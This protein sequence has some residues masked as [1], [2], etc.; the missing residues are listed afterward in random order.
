[1]M[2]AD[3]GSDFGIWSQ[4]VFV[5]I[6]ALSFTKSVALGMLFNFAVGSGRVCPA[7]KGGCLPTW[8][9]YAVKV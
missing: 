5:Q 1:M 6:L 7:V 8:G 2:V 4:S 9:G 3:L